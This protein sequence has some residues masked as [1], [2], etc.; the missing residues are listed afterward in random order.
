MMTTGTEGRVLV[1]LL[2]LGLAV[3]CALILALPGQSV[4]TKYLNDVLLF[5]DGAYRII[6][7]QVP[8]RDFH[9]ALGPVTYYVPAAGYWLSGNLG[10]AL[11]IGMALLILALAPIAIHILTSRLH[12]VIALP[13]A[14]F[15]F[16]VAAVPTNL[17]EGIEVLSFAMYYN[18]VGWAALGFLLVMHLPPIRP[19]TTQS[20]RDTVCAALL[21]LL[22]LYLKISYGI[23][24]LAFLILMLF[25]SR[26][27]SWGASALAA[28][29]GSCLIIEAFWRS[30]ADYLADLAIAGRV[31][32]G[33]DRLQV[34]PHGFQNLADYT[35]FVSLAALAL[36][37]TRNFRD[38][39][40]FG[41]CAGFGLML[42]S[43]NFQ[44]SGIITVSVG[45][46]VAVQILAH[47]N[48]ST[49]A[50]R[51]SVMFRCAYLLLLAALL[52]S[53]IHSAAAFGLHVRL[54]S[55][56]AGQA[57]PLPNF[58]GIRFARLGG[59]D[60]SPDFGPYLSTLEDGARALKSL[61]QEAR[62]IVVLDFVNPFS[63]GL[64]LEPANGDSTWNHWRR[65]L[66][67][68]N[69][70]PPEELFRN[71]RVVMDPKWP[72]EVSTAEGLRQIY[73]NYIIEHYELA[74]ETANWRVYVVRQGSR[75]TAGRSKPSKL[76]SQ[77][78]DT[79]PNGDEL[80]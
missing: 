35:L 12:L 11:P 25:D 1:S 58:S 53:G 34:L 15:L 48:D 61:N 38:I 59:A 24:G 26:Q 4:T 50:R 75:E 29:L 79:M 44:H 68:A 28:V 71:V 13:L 76:N 42:F 49:A 52:P 6:A 47:T 30:S 37:R 70:L 80:D 8:N 22:M 36:W 45:A 57:L 2:L 69:Y 77:I 33:L 14:L 66:D 65:T 16:L 19:G 46:A 64:G 55:T 72:I 73:A 67:E 63:A 60:A 20:V 5:V 7:G 10:G 40:Y 74:Q 56:D 9:S 54:A 27:R 41:F 18:R 39:L 43:Q 3:T 51:D 17:G 78:N 62:Q 21:V 23:V 31:S 32:G